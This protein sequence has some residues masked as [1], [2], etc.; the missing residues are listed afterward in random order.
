MQRRREEYPG[1]EVDQFT[2][3]PEDLTLDL[4]MAIMGTGKHAPLYLRTIAAAVAPLKDPSP[5][6][7]IEAVERAGVPARG[8]GDRG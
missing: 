5:E 6:E 8:A 4:M 7:F 1:W 2:V 3:G